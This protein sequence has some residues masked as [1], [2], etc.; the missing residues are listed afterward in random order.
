MDGIDV[1]RALGLLPEPLRAVLVLRELEGFS[2]AEIAEALGI[3]E[4]ASKVR[5]HRAR[6]QMHK[7]LARS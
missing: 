7:L 6:E 2:H 4:G 1:Q 3:R 5:L